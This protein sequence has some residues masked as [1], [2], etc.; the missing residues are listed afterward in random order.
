MRHRAAPI[1]KWTVRL[2]HVWMAQ[3]ATGAV[4]T[5]VACIEAWKVQK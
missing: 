5:M 1:P 4:T 2:G 3:V